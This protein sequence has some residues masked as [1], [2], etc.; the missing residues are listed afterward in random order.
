LCYYTAWLEIDK[1]VEGEGSWEPEASTIG[2][3]SMS[4]AIQIVHFDGSVSQWTCRS[5]VKK[6]SISHESL[7]NPLGW[8]N[9]F[10]YPKRSLLPRHRYLQQ[11]DLRMIA[12]PSSR[13]AKKASLSRK[14]PENSLE[15]GTYNKKL[16]K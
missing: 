15:I 14:V 1:E 13:E 10:S 2:E 8:K 12:T 11:E 4:R 9:D 5:P 16:D 3:T 6:N 7:N